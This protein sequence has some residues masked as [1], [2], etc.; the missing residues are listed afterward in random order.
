M[1][2]LHSVDPQIDPMMSVLENRKLRHGWVRESAQVT[3]RSAI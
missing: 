2:I 3:H 1:V